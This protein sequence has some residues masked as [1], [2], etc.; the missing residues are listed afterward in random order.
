MLN[1]C[2]NNTYEYVGKKY[3]DNGPIYCETDLN[4]D[5]ILR[6]P[7]NGITSLLYLLVVIYW[8]IR[9]KGEYRKYLVMMLC[10]ASVALSSIGTFI[11]H[12]FR[13]HIIF[14][15]FDWAPLLLAAAIASIYTWWYYFNQ[16][17]L[18]YA[19]LLTMVLMTTPWIVVLS[20]YG[21]QAMPIYVIGICYSFSGMS[22]LLPFILWM[23]RTS[24][25]K[26]WIPILGILSFL[27]GVG[28]RT[29]DTPEVCQIISVGTHFLWHIFGC[30]SIFFTAWLVYF[31]RYNNLI[32][33]RNRIK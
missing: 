27:F 25:Q 14:W 11:Y 1:S 16:Q 32:N 20:I 4:P 24:P 31:V 30:I 19:I 5:T 17:R 23:K 6:E 12:G 21:Q 8:L 33:Q 7:F 22:L 28:F 3:G 9:L 18:L 26:L 2:V 13:L 10:L 29:I 15:F